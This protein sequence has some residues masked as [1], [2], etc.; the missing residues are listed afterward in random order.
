[1]LDKFRLIFGLMNAKDRRQLVLIGF[2]SVVNGLLSVIGIASI[3]PF[4]GLISEPE[5]L[6]SNEYIQAF[7]RITGITSYTGVVVA[8]G[9]ISLFLV[10]VGN[11]L[12]AFDGWYGEVFGYKKERELSERLL[13]NYLHVDVLEF[14]R[15]KSSERAKEIL[16][17]VDRVILDTVFSMFDLISGII[18]SVFIV[19]LLLLVDW[20][21]TLVVT[22]TLLGVYLI[23]HNFTGVRL[24]RLGKQYADLE[25]DL[26]SD[27]LEALK[28]QKEIKLNGLSNYFVKRYSKSCGRMVRNRLKHSIISLMPQYA[29]EVAAYGVILLIAI[30]FALYSGPDTEPITLIGMYAFAAY[31]LMPSIADIFDSVENILF[32][33]AIL[34]D[35]VGSFEAM[36]QAGDSSDAERGASESIA[37]SNIS[38][39]YSPDSAFHLESLHLDFPVNVMTCIKGRTGCGKSTILHLVAGLYR[40]AAGAIHID[41]EA[42]DVYGS[43]HWKSRIGFVPAAVNVM[44]ASL[45][46]N[47]ALGTPVADID[48]QKVK[49]VSE[50][51]DLD[52]HI[53]GLRHGYESIYGADGLSFSSGQIQKIGLARALYRN[54]AVL[55]LDESTDALDL[56][57]ETLVLSRLNQIEGMTIIFVSH[58]PSVQEHAAKTI[59]LEE[60]LNQ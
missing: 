56:K 60:V 13:H 15:K 14:E 24:D 4:I 55:L 41:G 8:F 22:T 21:V 26:Y 7:T 1:L 10:V 30:Y 12:S 2:I 37:L 42:I 17:D 33:S 18:V 32:G 29:I 43:R 53:M 3:L 19:G 47:I 9:S 6:N 45:Y 58:R 48:R 51:V 52:A 50:L 59:D 40:P 23:I 35:F 36:E 20:G 16:S 46:E 27:V 44:Q 39:R 31:R 25:A 54:P 38:F 49:A 11:V 57:T 34:E 5:L 28:L